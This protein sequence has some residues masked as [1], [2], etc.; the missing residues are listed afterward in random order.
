MIFAFKILR[1]KLGVRRGAVT[2]RKGG[3]LEEIGVDL[4]VPE[5][6]WDLDGCE[7]WIT[8]TKIKGAIFLRKVGCIS[9]LVPQPGIWGIC[10][11]QSPNVFHIHLLQLNLLSPSVSL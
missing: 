7:R 9:R 11:E 1:L 2:D 10:L 5:T 8:V 3:R 4:G 6:D